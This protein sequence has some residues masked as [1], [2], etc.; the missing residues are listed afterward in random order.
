MNR[1]SDAGVGVDSNVD[2]FHQRKYD[3]FLWSYSKGRVRVIQLRANE[4]NIQTK[5]L[6]WG[7]FNSSDPQYLGEN[8]NISFCRQNCISKDTPDILIIIIE[9]YRFHLFP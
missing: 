4:S 2:L 8:D 5:P 6:E 3:G 9:L 1:E 7:Q